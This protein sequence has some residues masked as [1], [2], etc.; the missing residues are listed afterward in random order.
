[1]TLLYANNRW[2]EADAFL[3]RLQQVGYQSPGLD[4]LS[5]RVI[6]AKVTSRRLCTQRELVP[7]LQSNDPLAHVWL[8]QA[9]TVAANQAR[10]ADERQ[11][12]LDEGK[13]FL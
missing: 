13:P 2:S 6:C 12:L 7:R 4:L 11:K 5:S 9:L 8:G 10:L 1:M 3:N